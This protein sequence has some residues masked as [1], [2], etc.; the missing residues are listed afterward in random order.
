MK[1][2]FEPDFAARNLFAIDQ[3]GHLDVAGLDR[4]G[5]VIELGGLSP[6]GDVLQPRND[7]P[8]AGCVQTVDLADERPLVVGPRDR[9]LAVAGDDPEF[10]R[11]PLGHFA[12]EERGL[13]FWRGC[14][15]GLSHHRTGR[16][17]P[18]QNKAKRRCGQADDDGFVR[19]FRVELGLPLDHKTTGCGQDIVDLGLRHGLGR[20]AQ[21]GGG[22]IERVEGKPGGI[23]SGG[24]GDTAGRAAA[25]GPVPLTI[26]RGEGD[27]R[28][29]DG[30]VE[31]G[32][33]EVLV[34]GG[35]ELGRLTPHR[36]GD[37]GRRRAK[38]SR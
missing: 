31:K 29:L 23:G 17:I 26:T 15:Q 24:C 35:L 25:Q 12:D 38:R 1:L 36:A 14:L 13:S 4:T 6:A 34:L 30:A 5:G 20:I 10:G 8:R 19:L 7:P 22:G 2:V 11:L 33:V 3:D 27:R 28:G 9:E 37:T 21:V 18:L 32:G 16:G